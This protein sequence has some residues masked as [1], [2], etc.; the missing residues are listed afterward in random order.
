MLLLMLMLLLLLL[1][2]NMLGNGGRR[3]L[4]C[5]SA[6]EHER[7]QKLRAEKSNCTHECQEHGSQ[8]VA[9]AVL[10]LLPP[11]RPTAA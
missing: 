9:E 8:K 7:T 5:I 4:L 3:Q 10:Q 2:L 6:L 1:L 11:T